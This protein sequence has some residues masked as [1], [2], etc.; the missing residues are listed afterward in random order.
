[1]L[2]TIFYTDRCKKQLR[3]CVLQQQ[4][5]I[6]YHEIKA[7]FDLDCPL[8]WTSK[9]QAAYRHSGW[10][11]STAFISSYVAS[12]IKKE[13]LK[14]DE[15]QIHF[16]I[17]CLRYVHKVKRDEDH[18]CFDFFKEQSVSA[19]T[20]FVNNVMC[21]KYVSPQKTLSWIDRPEQLDQI[22]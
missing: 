11:S 10:F 6:S 9:S 18:I 5:D 19:R 14:L 3:P 17:T 1:M 7:S 8:C 4:L 21:H 22:R 16:V 15:F 12:R 13:I 2:W 20:N